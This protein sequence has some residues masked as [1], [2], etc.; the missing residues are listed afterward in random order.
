VIDYLCVLCCSCFVRCVHSRNS[1]LAFPQVAALYEKR[2]CIML[3]VPSEV[4]RCNLIPSFNVVRR[5][6]GDKGAKGK[7][8]Q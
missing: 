6:E 2:V 5:G 4:H 1:F 3:L 8:K 7:K